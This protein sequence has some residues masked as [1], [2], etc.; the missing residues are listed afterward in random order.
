MLTEQWAKDDPRFGYNGAHDFGE[1]ISKEY[2]WNFG[3]SEFLRAGFSSDGVLVTL[4]DIAY[5]DGIHLFTDPTVEE[6]EQLVT[7]LER[8]NA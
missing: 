3:A 6:M 2:V 5:E 1:T 7:A 4:C 8:Q